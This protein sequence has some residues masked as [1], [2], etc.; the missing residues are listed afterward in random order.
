MKLNTTAR[1]IISAI[2]S[3]LV[4]ALIFKKNNSVS[5]GDMVIPIFNF[6]FGIIQI[7]SIYIIG[8]ILKQSSNKVILTIILLQIIEFIIM[9]KFG[10]EIHQWIKK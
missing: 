3:I 6:M 1:I 2:I 9:I 4:F 5:G 7:I 10:Y 8:R